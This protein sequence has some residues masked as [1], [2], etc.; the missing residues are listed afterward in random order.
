MSLGCIMS[1]PCFGYYSLSK[2]QSCGIKRKTHHFVIAFFRNSCSPENCSVL[3]RSA[4]DRIR[5][6]ITALGWK[7]KKPGLNEWT[8]QIGKRTF[9][10]SDEWKET[11][12]SD[13]FNE[14]NMMVAFI[15]DKKGPHYV[16]TGWIP[17]NNYCSTSASQWTHEKSFQR[18]D[19]TFLHL[20][21]LII[22]TVSWIM[23]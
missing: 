2:T 22:S 20:R 1:G 10:R 4:R 16:Q 8:G 13:R 14:A 21:L 3:F 5:D 7:P 12:D 15:E 18:T 11:T 6:V 23:T 9:G 19:T 17:S